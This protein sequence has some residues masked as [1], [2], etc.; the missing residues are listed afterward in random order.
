MKI[1]YT[2]ADGR[3]HELEVSDEVGNFHLESLEAIKSNDRRETR[4]HTQLSTFQYEDV[5]FFD[6]GTN[7]CNELAMSDSVS[8]AMERLSDRQRH[9]ITMIYIEGWSFTELAK[10]EGRDESTIRKA[11]KAA[12]EKFKKFYC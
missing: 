8:R 2:D 9:L 3:I 10:A 11:T 4:R 7:L 12:V 1:N 5:R 6:S